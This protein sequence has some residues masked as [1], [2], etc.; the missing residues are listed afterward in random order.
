MLEKKGSTI[1]AFSSNFCSVGP[2]LLADIFALN[3]EWGKWS[4]GA[5]L[6]VTCATTGLRPPEIN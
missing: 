1:A 6:G 4:W 5:G 3:G 2:E